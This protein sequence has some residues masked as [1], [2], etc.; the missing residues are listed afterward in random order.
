[1][2]LTI[3]HACLLL[4]LLLL[5]PPQADEHCADGFGCKPSLAFPE[6]MTCQPKVMN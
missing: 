2:V 1:M 5:L 4:L 3:P 6:Y